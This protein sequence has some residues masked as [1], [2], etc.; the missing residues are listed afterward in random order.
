MK[1]RG[2]FFTAQK[3]RFSFFSEGLCSLLFLF[4]ICAV[5]QRSA[6]ESAHDRP[7]GRRTADFFPTS[8]DHGVVGGAAAEKAEARRGPD[9]E[10]LRHSAAAPASTPRPTPYPAAP[11]NPSS[12]GAL[13]PATSPSVAAADTG[14]APPQAQQ[15][16]G[17][18]QTLRVLPPHPPLRG[19]QGRASH[20]RARAGLPRSYHRVPRYLR[21]SSNPTGPFVLDAVFRNYICK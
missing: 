3:K 5:W 7:P 14:G 11:R 6:W 8:L 18:A 17:A 13:R 2:Y 1:P 4:P 9:P 21:P 12:S 19:A 16:G 15:P 20:A 10:S